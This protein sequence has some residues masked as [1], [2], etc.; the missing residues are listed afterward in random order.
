MEFLPGRVAVQGPFLGT[1]SALVHVAQL[2][3]PPPRGLQARPRSP[4]LHS[5]FRVEALPQRISVSEVLAGLGRPAR[6]ETAPG[7]REQR[8][9]VPL[10]FGV[11]G[12]ELGPVSLALRAG[13]V[14]AVLG[15]PGSGKT[16]L[17]AALPA[18]NSPAGGWLR[19]AAGTDPADFWAG[20]HARARAGAL[21]PGAVLLADDIDLQSEDSN[22]QLLG[23]NSLGWTVVL[24]AGFSP[25]LQQR[26]PLAQCARRQGTGILICPRSLLDGDLFGVRFELEASPP[27]GRAVLISDGQALAV[28]LADPAAG[29]AAPDAAK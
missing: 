7:V 21:N 14:L 19:P 20:L 26:V 12:D 1:T 16:A 13:S 10:R 24:T 27:P 17:L 9:H 5:P 22:R 6:E 11:G 29:S 3:G 28:Q 2:Y 8:A 23:L 15:G 18:L 4:V 25:A